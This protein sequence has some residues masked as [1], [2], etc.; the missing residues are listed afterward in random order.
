M[1]KRTNF[2]ISIS[3]PPPHATFFTFIVGSFVTRRSFGRIIVFSNPFYK[4]RAF[5]RRQF[6]SHCR[7]IANFSFPSQSPVVVVTFCE[8]RLFV[9]S[10]PLFFSFLLFPLFLVIKIVRMSDDNDSDKIICFRR[11]FR[12][13]RDD[14]SDLKTEKLFSSPS[15]TFQ[16]FF[17]V[18]QAKPTPFNFFLLK[19]Y[20]CLCAFGEG[21]DRFANAGSPAK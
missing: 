18:L 7:K 19:T 8:H 4:A 10:L 20:A 13:H 9:L 21:C 17:H 5:R 2:A 16:S 6:G 14:E 11:C 15:Q 3:S 12:Y 1:D